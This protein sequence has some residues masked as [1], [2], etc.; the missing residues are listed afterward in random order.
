M[1]GNIRDS[2]FISRPRTLSALYFPGKFP[3]EY[4]NSSICRSL[5]HSIVLVALQYIPAIT[6]RTLLHST[7]PIALQRQYLPYSTALYY[8][9]SA[10]TPVLA[11]L[12]CTLP[13]SKRYNNIMCRIP[14]YS[15]VLKALQQHNVPYS[16]V[17]YRTR[18]AMTT[19][20]AV[21]YC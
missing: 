7:V 20:L 6:C 5:L 10:T 1:V 4:C 15:T 18:S 11:V 16:T 12:N 17:L 21:L 19:V 2:I 14:L 3:I 8:T 13:Y 9:H